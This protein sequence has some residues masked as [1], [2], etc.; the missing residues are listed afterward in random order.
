MASLVAIYSG[1]GA[2]IDTYESIV[3]VNCVVRRRLGSRC[4]VSSSVAAPC[5]AA[6]AQFLGF[7]RRP[8]SR[9]IVSVVRAVR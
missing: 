2:K 6:A 5:F 9:V 3:S 1:K 8:W 7:G 4:F